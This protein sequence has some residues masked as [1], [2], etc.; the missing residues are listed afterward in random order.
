MCTLVSH[1]A[2][3]PRVGVVV[4]HYNGLDDTLEC[5][6]SLAPVRSDDVIVWVVDNASVDDPAA[7]INERFPWCRLY[8]N[9]TNEGW[10]GGNNAGI[11]LA[12]DAGCDWVMLLNNDTRVSPRIV[13]RLLVVAAADDRLGVIGPL[14]N[15][16]QPADQIQT[17]CCFFNPADSPAMLASQLP[18]AS[19]DTSAPQDPPVVLPTDIVNG[20]CMLIRTDVIRDIGMIDEAFFLVHEESD[21]CLRVREAG[22]RCGVLAESHVWHKH[23][24]SFGREVSPLQRY[25]ASRN[26]WRLIAKHRNWPD[27]KSPAAS[28][29]MLLLHT[30]HLVDYEQERGNSAAAR[31][32]VDGVADAWAGRFGPRPMRWRPLAW[33]AHRGLQLISRLRARIR[34][35]RSFV[36]TGGAS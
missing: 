8:R 13:D 11:R 2:Q 32:V 17:A 30:W 15:E 27:G 20:C 35:S 36:V 25:F 26:A 4:L 12:L 21:F 24:A 34:P 31:A 18:P 10:A 3:S 16:W 7:T 14:I 9:P 6:E 33:L 29:R 28:R 1:D 19:T 22:Y 5:L 23:S